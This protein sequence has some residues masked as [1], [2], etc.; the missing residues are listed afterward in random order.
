M[1]NQSFPSN[2]SEWT[3]ETID[4]LSENSHPENSY[5]EYKQ[6][7]EYPNRGDPSETEW[8]RNVERGIN[9]LGGSVEKAGNNLYRAE[10]PP[11]LR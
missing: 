7:L 9:T 8:R 10:L 6:Y 1:E 2:I 3:W 5:L 4:S 11:V